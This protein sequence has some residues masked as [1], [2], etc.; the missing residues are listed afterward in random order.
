MS[1]D[2]KTTEGQADEKATSKKPTHICVKHLAEEGTLYKP[3]QEITLTKAR[4]KA[5]GA[6]VK[7]I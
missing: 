5:L 4:A 6:L 1:D 7:S 3:G 2:T